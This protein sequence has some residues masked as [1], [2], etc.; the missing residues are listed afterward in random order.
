MPPTS[1]PAGD[2]AP[3]PGS[4][5]P[6]GV[7]IGAGAGRWAGPATTA[8][9]DAI[10]FRIEPDGGRPPTGGWWWLYHWLSTQLTM[11]E[12]PWPR[13]HSASRDPAELPRVGLVRAP[14]RDTASQMSTAA[15]TSPVTATTRRRR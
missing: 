15:R 3:S 8:A 14:P 4:G 2:Q 5:G 9:G 12:P 10:G 6:A 13:A 1:R 7:A 11:L